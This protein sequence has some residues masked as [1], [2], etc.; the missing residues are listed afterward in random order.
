VCQ[1]ELFDIISSCVVSQ[2]RSVL[3][4]VV[5]VAEA[6][7]EVVAP[8]LVAVKAETR[9]DRALVPRL[10]PITGIPKVRNINIIIMFFACFAHESLFV[11]CVFSIWPSQE[12]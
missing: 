9:L 5:D 10:A 3:G 6:E 12:E 11:S 8:L 4:I 2:L 1:P 7:V